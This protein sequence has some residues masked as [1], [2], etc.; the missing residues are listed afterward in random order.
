MADVLDHPNS[1]KAN[2]QHEDNFTFSDGSSVSLIS[3][4]SRPIHPMQQV[5]MLEDVKLQLILSY[6]ELNTRSE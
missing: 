6:R 4:S 3:S 2:N 5:Y 1:R